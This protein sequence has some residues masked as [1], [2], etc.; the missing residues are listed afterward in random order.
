MGLG[1]RPPIPVTP[2]TRVVEH[3]ITKQKNFAG[4]FKRSGKLH[5]TQRY[6][7]HHIGSCS[8]LGVHYIISREKNTFFVL[9]EF[10][11][12][13]RTGV[14]TDSCSGWGSLDHERKIKLFPP[15]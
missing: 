6:N 14:S 11:D 8:G 15:F 1:T 4:D 2:L 7:I 10:Q 9:E 13:A 12:K 5:G 3:Y